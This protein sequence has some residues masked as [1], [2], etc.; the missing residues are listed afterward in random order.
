M[1]EDISLPTGAWVLLGDGR[2]ALF[3]RNAGTPMHV[4]LVTE[5]VLQQDNPATR[6][7]GSDQPGRYLGPDGAGRSALEETDWHQL[8]ED[9]FAREI[10]GLLYRS[11]HTRRF[12]Q[13]VVVAPPKVLGSLRAALHPEVARCVVAEVPKDLTSHPLPE[14]SRVLSRAA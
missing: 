14:I 9:R 3:L 8:A 4:Q 12:Q 5:R 2:K 11:A 6:E 13:L 7:Q 10:A 1:I